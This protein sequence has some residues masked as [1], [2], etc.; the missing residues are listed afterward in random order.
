M[1]SITI[2]PSAHFF[3]A[4][5]ADGT[6]TFWAVSDAS[7]PLL[8]RTL[9]SLEAHRSN[10]TA[11]HSIPRE[12]IFKLSWSGFPNSKD[13]RGGDTVLTVLG[14]FKDTNIFGLTTFL[15]PPFN[16]KDSPTE[17]PSVAQDG[18]DPFMA[19]AVLES[20][21]E[22]CYFTY[23][24]S[25]P[26]QDF[27]L[28][29]RV[30]PHFNNT[31]DPY[32]ILLLVD[33]GQNARIL[34]SRE[35]PP[36][37]FISFG[38]QPLEHPVKTGEGNLHDLTATLASISMNTQPQLVDLPFELSGY[39]FFADNCRILVLP[40]EMYPELTKGPE[41]SDK[42]PTIRL[43]GGTAHM[44]HSHETKSF[45]V[46]LFCATHVRIYLKLPYSTN[47]IVYLLPLTGI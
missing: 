9:D 1:T 27:Y 20:L 29:P 6:M 18:F 23:S 44:E 38:G 11:Y 39:N 5:H 24:T 47:H 8:V 7:Q 36:P 45:K 13:P 2:H 3:V 46:S 42:R 37:F 40:K 30:S 15:F 28:I 10:P 34:E 14:G 43:S 32:A 17:P 4:G 16:P 35:F 33:A 41:A 12:P 22:R 26:V 19:T 31:Y 21:I 25:G